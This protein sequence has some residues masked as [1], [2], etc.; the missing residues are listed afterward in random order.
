[1]KKLLLVALALNLCSFLKGQAQSQISSQILSTGGVQE[2]WVARYDT[3]S[4]ANDRAVAMRIDSS[5]N[6]YVTGSSGTVKY[7]SAGTQAWV[8]NRGNALA[9]DGNGNVYVTEGWRWNGGNHEYATIKYNAAGTQQWVRTYD[10]PGYTPHS[11]PANAVAVDV[12]GNVYMTGINGNDYF[13]IK[14]NS[15]GTQQWVATYNGPNNGPDDAVALAIDGSGN[16]YV[17]GRSGYY[18][19]FDENDISGYVYRYDYATVKYNSAGTQEWVK[20]YGN[21]SNA[22]DNEDEWIDNPT[23]AVDA[24]DN[25]YVITESGRTIKY[26]SAGIQEWEVKGRVLAVDGAGN[27]YMAENGATVKYNVAGTQDWIVNGSGL[28]V[29]DGA[30]NV[31]MTGSDKTVKYNSA[32]NQEWVANGSGVALAVDADGNVYVAGSIFDASTGYDYVTIKYTQIPPPAADAGPDKTICAGNTVPI[33]GSPTGSGGHGGPYAFSWT[34]TTG[35]HDPTAPNP[36]ATPAATTEYTVKVTDASGATAT[37]KIV[38]TTNPCAVVVLP[39]PNALNINEAANIALN[40]ANPIDPATLTNGTIRVNGS[41]SGLH[42]SSNITYYSGTRTASFDPANDFKPGEV[43]NVTLTNGITSASGVALSP[44]TWSFAIQSGGSSVF[45]NA[46]NISLGSRPGAITTGDFDNDGDLDLAVVTSGNVSILKNSGSGVFIASSTPA[47][48]S[49]LSSIVAS[50]FDSD[51]DLDLAGT[52]SSNRTLSILMNNGSGV[53]ASSSTPRVGSNPN[54]IAAGDFDGDGDWD[55]AVANWVSKDVSILKNDG[56]GV[57]TRSSSVSGLYGFTAVVVGDFDGD[58]DLDLATVEAGHVSILKNDGNGVFTPSSLVVVGISPAAVITGDF[59]GDG[60]LDL[61]VADR[62]SGVFILKNNGNGAFARTTLAGVG[63]YSNSVAAGDFDGDLDL[64]LAVTNTLSSNV[65][66]LKNDGNGAFTPSP[67]VSGV[68]GNN[69]AVVGDFDGD[70]DL[71]LAAA[72]SSYNSSNIIAILKN[73]RLAEAGSN[74]EICPGQ[75]VALGGNPTAINGT[76]PYTYSWTPDDGSLNNA[77]SA[78][79]LAKPTTTTTYTVEVTDANGYKDTDQVTVTVT[80]SKAGWS[81]AH[82][83]DVDDVIFGIDQGAITKPAPRD[84]RGL[85]ISPD[86]RF[87]YLGYSKSFNQRV[88]RKIDLSV[89]DPANNHSAVVAQLKLPPGSQPAR[90]IAT[91]DKGRVYLALGTKIEVYNSNLQTPPLHTISGLTACEG[92]AVRRENGTLA[93]YATERLDKTL[94]RFVLV[95]SAGET[96]VSSS[97]TGLDGDGEVLIIG[98]SRPRGLDIASDGTAWIADLGK[99]RIYRVNSAGKTVDSTGVK[100]PMDLAIDESRGEVYVSQNTLRTIK[101]LSLSTGKIKRTL[102]PPA[103]DLNL[104]LEGETPTGAA[105][106]GA[107]CGIDVAS[108]KRVYVANE[109]GRSL[110]AGNLDSPFSNIGDNNDVKAADTDPV[111]LATGNVLSKSGEEEPEEEEEVAEAVAVTSYELAQNYPNPFSPPERGFAGN[112]STVINF[113]LPQ[114]GRVTVNVYNEI[115]QLVRTLVDH[116]M[117]AGRHSIHWNGRDQSGQ[118]AAAGLYLYRIIV[119]KNNGGAVFTQTRS[120]T[121]LK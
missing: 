43:V 101:V 74:A 102:T 76:P 34:P 18:E 40:F 119:R 65:S 72:N 51:G 96:I 118:I 46:G 48:G 13:T 44:Y 56:Y 54:S 14:Y 71:D 26:N 5:G 35:L 41:Q 112:S 85:A 83:V 10:G 4:H 89:S 17:T 27:I 63:N 15:S 66:I 52:N 1:M 95:E 45:A 97:K 79:P 47:V 113:A 110:L 30:G 98:G 117:A 105:G 61:A 55:L 109:Q 11:D 38:V 99:N 50:D 3:P 16:V 75:S 53:F 69:S 116:E 36:I 24:D 57:F 64:D 82:I 80:V 93:V 31:Y 39:A 120:M 86:E 115:G 108:C 22:D 78:N 87:L 49:S 7:N 9:V 94:K 91:D 114:A 20:T 121:L 73:G 23:L 29:V 88:V 100:S 104:D 106:S 111:L 21:G 58:G 37:D 67:P 59:D 60:D 84:N 103:A 107:L 68:N 70:G 81:V 19:P 92:V 8:V 28:L 2:A 6:T 12:D 90:D 42:T 62:Y 32:G 25:V 33:G 77:T